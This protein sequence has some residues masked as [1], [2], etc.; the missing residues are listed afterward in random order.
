M[1]GKSIRIDLQGA[2][3]ARIFALGN[4]GDVPTGFRW[5]GGY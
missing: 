4:A 3:S 5:L 2:K 1:L